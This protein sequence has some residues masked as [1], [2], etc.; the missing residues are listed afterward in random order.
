MGT[1]G[2][3][4]CEFLALWASTRAWPLIMDLGLVG[5]PGGSSLDFVGSDALGWE[6]GL[7]IC[8]LHCSYP[9]AARYSCE[10]LPPDVGHMPVLYHGRKTRWVWNSLTPCDALSFKESS[11]LVPSCP[12]LKSSFPGVA[13]VC[14][15]VRGFPLF[16]LCA[17]WSV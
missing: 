16:L 17:A 12:R 9:V 6:N 14:T 3:L 8:M 11:H 10:L 4:G 13:V 2:A 1:E 5:A 7:G 15:C